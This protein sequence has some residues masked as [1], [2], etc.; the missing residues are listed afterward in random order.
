[1]QQS[2]PIVAIVGRTNVGKSTLFNQLVGRRIA[3]VEDVPGVTRDRNYFMVDRHGFPFTLVDTGGL[4]GDAD[5]EMQFAVRSQ[6][7]LALSDADLIIAVVDGAQGVHPLDHEV[8][9]VVRQSKK[10]VLW[11]INKCESPKTEAEAVEFYGLGIEE[12]RCISAAHNVGIE[13]LI[14]EIRQQLQAQEKLLEVSAPVEAAARPIQ[15]A[16][17]GKPNVGKSTLVNKILGTDR[18][19]VSPLAGTTVDS[20]DVE[21]RRDGKV[22]NL[23]DTA[24]LRKKARIEDLTVERFGNLRTL[25]SVVRSDVVVLV[26]DAT[27][28]APGEQDSKIAGLVHERGKG[29]VIVVN[30]WD[31]VEKDH[32]TVKAYEEAIREV[33]KFAP[34]APIIFVSALTGRRAP[35]IL[36]TANE[37]YG[38]RLVRI[39]TPEVNK[40]FTGFFKAKP[41]PVHRG[42]PVRLLYATQIGVAP[43]SFALMVSNPKKINFSYQ[44]FLK[45]MLRKHYSFEG[46]DVKFLI[47]KR[48]GEVTE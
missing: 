35:N 9:K 17:V 4:V 27:Q 44:R 24:G 2:L 11:I 33:F 45:N 41:P 31:L 47:K 19:V 18:L 39:P 3:V 46:T 40:L 20:I 43:P 48:G 25:R 32:K 21:I 5:A 8:A 12:F 15:I 23:I 14:E 26:L 13:K 6:A 22:F 10:P 36:K 42:A 37:V 38:N 28:G 7:E 29:L 1:M 16:I 34:Y 30:K